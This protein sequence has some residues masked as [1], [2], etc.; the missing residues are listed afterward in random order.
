MSE[1]PRITLYVTG[2]CPFCR[3]A[4]RLLDQRSIPYEVRDAGDPKVRMEIM[5]RTGWRTV[6]V[7]LLDGELIGG[8]DQLAAL[9]QNGELA[10]RL[11]T[12]A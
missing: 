2:F 10:K 3:L 9:D 8:Y 7:I 4:E 6:P 1:T 11:N 5:E 12:L